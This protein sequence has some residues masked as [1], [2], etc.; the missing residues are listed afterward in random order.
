MQDKKTQQ[1]QKKMFKSFMRTQLNK[2]V[3]KYRRTKPYTAPFTRFGYGLTVTDTFSK[4]ATV[5]PMKES[6]SENFS[7][8][9]E[10]ELWEDG[11]T[12]VNQ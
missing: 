3:Q 2:Q 9:F 5:V 12:N 4:L 6:N 11:D 7:I 8:S 1:W 10:R